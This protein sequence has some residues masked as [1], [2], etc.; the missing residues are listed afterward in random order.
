MRWEWPTSSH[1]DILLCQ[2]AM[3]IIL[4][5]IVNVKCY[6]DDI[7][8]TGPS[9]TAHLKNLEEVLKRLKE[10][11]VKANQAKCQFLQDSVVFWATKLL[12]KVYTPL[13]TSWMQ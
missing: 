2:K 5:G 1:T 8:I 9:D 6:I 7:L 11:G 10:H 13:K 4:H 12:H 3:D